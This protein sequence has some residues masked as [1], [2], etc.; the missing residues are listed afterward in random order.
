MIEASKGVAV[1]AVELTAGKVGHILATWP[2]QPPLPE[3]VND[4]ELEPAA[5]VEP[6]T[7]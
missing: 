3:A 4:F 7:F 1:E 5:G 6:A 2:K